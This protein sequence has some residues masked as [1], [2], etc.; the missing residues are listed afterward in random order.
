MAATGLGLAAPFASRLAAL[1]GAPVG[2]RPKRL[3]IIYLPHGWPIE[4]VDPG[5][6]GAGLF[7]ASSVLAPLAPHSDLV[8]VVRGIAMND[9]A[10]NHAA[11]R[12][13]LTG[14]A[15]GGT[16]DSIDRVI[17]DGL[18]VDAHV[19]GAIPYAAGAGFNSDAFLVKHGAWVRP[20]EDPAA[21]ADALLGSLG[22]GSPRPGTED[23]SAFRRQALEL[24]EAELESLHTAVTDLTSERDKL[25]V[26]LDAV[27]SLKAGGGTPDLLSCDERPALPSVDALAGLDVMDPA[28]FARV[29]DGHLEVAA[30]ALT[31]GTAQVLTL[32]NLWVNADVNM[33]FTGGPG[34]PKNHHD[35]I[36]HSWDAA[37]RA[38]FADVQRWFYERITQQLV[39][40]LA[41]TVDPSDD[42]GTRSVLDNTL[43]YVCSE[44]SDGANHNS[45]ASDVWLDGAPHGSYLPAILIGGGSGATVSGE[46][47]TVERS[48]LELMATLAAA[49]DVP[50]V[51]I[52]GQMP[53]AIPEVLS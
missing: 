34:V 47:V 9:G 38:E 19:L 17:A 5:G 31:C 1:A 20:T 53:A 13:T 15:E 25:Q 21:A 11:I 40:V 14:F 32:Q 23:A 10:N 2:D 39:S 52:G 29:L 30:A 8:T 28:N 44:V 41:D 27:R 45:D 12:A 7:D 16:G 26:H 36:S 43:I 37:G 46:T 18:G 51:S 49:M 24:T 50:D 4:H 35:P 6:Q 42:D 3:M 22:E 33:G 48:N